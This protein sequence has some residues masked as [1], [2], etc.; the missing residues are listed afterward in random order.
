M[1]IVSVLKYNG[2]PASTP[3][4]MPASTPA[5]MPASTPASTPASM[6]ASMPASTPASHYSL[7]LQLHKCNE[8]LPHQLF[9]LFHNPYVLY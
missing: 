4:S 8:A 3:A 5:S 7:P 6:P 1:L 2:M 9:P